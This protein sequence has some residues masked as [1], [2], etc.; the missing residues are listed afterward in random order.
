MSRIVLCPVLNSLKNPRDSMKS[1][2]GS[3]ERGSRCGVEV[4]VG[5]LQ[6]GHSPLTCLTN[7]DSL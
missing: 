3:S 6:P 5:V 1:L 7:V 4:G 2:Q